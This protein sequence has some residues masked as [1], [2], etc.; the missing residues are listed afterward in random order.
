MFKQILGALENSTADIIY[1][2]EHDVLYHPSH[3]D[4]TP[5]TPDKFY[6]NQNFW[7]LRIDDGHALHYDANQLSGMCAYRNLVIKEYQNRV[8]HVEAQGYDRNFGFEPGTHDHNFGTW[9]SALPIIDI[10]HHHNLTKNLW[11]QTEFRN[12]KNCQ[13]WIE[14]DSE[15][16]GWGK[17]ANLIKKFN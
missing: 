1:F 2:C 6:Y 15:I 16:P 14:T 11:S 4:F 7:K 13:G 8:K 9:K 17:T 12:K 5:P 10:R 3:S